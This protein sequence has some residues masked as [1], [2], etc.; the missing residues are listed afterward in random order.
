MALKIVGTGLG[1]TGTK[2]MQTALNTLGFGPCHHMTEMFSHPESVPAWIAAAKGAQNWD[3]LFEGYQSMVDWPGVTYW[4]E[5]VAYYPEAKVLHTVRDPDKWFDSTQVTIFS[6]ANLER[7]TGRVA[8]PGPMLD[9]FMGL[10]GDLYPH[11]AD[12]KYM[13]DF[14]HRHDAEVRATVPKE[15]LLVYEAGSGWEPLC[16]WLGVPV[17]AEPYPHENSRRAFAERVI[18]GHP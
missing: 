8:E 12:R 14:Y 17:P 6:P 16:A 13:I 10:F 4:R 18:D 15:R 9:F 5:L 7:I 2:S 3:E 1:R 11:M